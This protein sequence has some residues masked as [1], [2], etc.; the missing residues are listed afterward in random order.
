MGPGPHGHE[1]NGDHDQ[2]AFHEW[3]IGIASLLPVADR[4]R[5]LERVS[6]GAV[7]ADRIVREIMTGIALNRLG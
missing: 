5:P 7:S 3:L 1:Q 4:S 6:D 2:R